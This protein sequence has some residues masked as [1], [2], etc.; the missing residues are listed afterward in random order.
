MYE[1]ALY[2]VK[3]KHDKGTVSFTTSANTHESA[4]NIV[5]S[6]ERAPESAVISVKKGK[7]IYAN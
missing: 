3:L 6:I 1:I 7:V 5:C 2:T 4:K